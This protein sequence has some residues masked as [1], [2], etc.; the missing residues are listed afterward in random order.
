MAMEVAQLFNAEVGIGITGY[1]KPLRALSIKDSFAYF[2][3]TRDAKVVL[4]KKIKGD[5]STSLFNNQLT[6][7]NK[8][9]DSLL[10]LLQEE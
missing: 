1:A 7:T 10:S 9:I 6:F 2:T 5:P 3:I 4:S 8:V